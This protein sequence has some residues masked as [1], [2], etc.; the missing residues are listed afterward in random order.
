MTLTLQTNIRR[1]CDTFH[2]ER[3]R[4]TNFAM[5]FVRDRTAAEDLVNDSFVTFWERRETLAEETVC[6][7]YFYTI[8]KNKCLNYLRD[9]QTRSKIHD[10]LHDTSR[11]LM[12]YDLASLESYDPNLIFSSEIQSILEEQLRS[13]PEL[14]R[15]IF[16]DNRFE[17]KTYE[18]IAQKY[19]ISVWKVARE[20]QTTLQTLR[21]ALKDYLPVVLLLLSMRR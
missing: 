10:D 20:I 6:E 15:C 19:G 17:H 1:F 8:V 16:H 12:Q 3:A 11:R 7:A 5:R 18:E 14:T 13:L 21:L 4:Y 9:M 2:Q